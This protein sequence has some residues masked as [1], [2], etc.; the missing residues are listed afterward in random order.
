[1]VKPISDN[2]KTKR[3]GRPRV[4]ANLIGVRMPPAGLAALDGCIKAYA[5]DLSR[6]EAIR[7]LVEAGL[8]VKK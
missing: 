8:K 3:A 2:R 1:M 4:G 6:L 5:P 7:R